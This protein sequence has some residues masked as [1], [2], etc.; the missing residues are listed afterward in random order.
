MKKIKQQAIYL[1]AMLL[2]GIT[3]VVIAYTGELNSMMA[4]MGTALVTVCAIN[5]IRL[6]NIAKDPQRVR[7]MEIAQHE[8]RN[9][10]ISNLAAK[11]A[12]VTTIGLEYVVMLVM[13]FLQKDEIASALGFLVCGQLL[14]YV[15]FSKYYS[16]KY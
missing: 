14:I 15:F 16:K 4:G 12:M 1:G 13:V 3:M 9:L 10:F 2:V 11:A 8:E 6:R 5:L 7:Q